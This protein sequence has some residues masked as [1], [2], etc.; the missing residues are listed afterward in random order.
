[1]RRRAHVA[2][3]EEGGR[4]LVT[5]QVA[6]FLAQR[7]VNYVRRECA[8]AEVACDV[9]TRTVLLDLDVVT[10]LLAHRGHRNTLRPLRLE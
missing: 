7:H 4:Q 1:M 6:A 8:G 9:A 10:E 3:R 2:P 5:R